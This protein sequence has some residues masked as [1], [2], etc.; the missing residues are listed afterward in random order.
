MAKTAKIQYLENG[1]SYGL[2]SYLILTG[3]GTFY[4]VFLIMC[5]SK[6]NRN[7][8]NRLFWQKWLK[9]AKI[10]Y[11]ENYLSCGLGSYLI[12][13]AIGTFYSVFLIMYMFKPNIKS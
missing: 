8:S 9:S 5:M 6:P 7:G 11:L 4:S 13:T 3:K 12:L 10:Q 1:L 2:G